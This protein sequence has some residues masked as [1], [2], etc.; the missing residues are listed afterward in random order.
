MEI[1][2][3]TINYVKSLKITNS[4]KKILLGFL[5]Q[6]V[7]HDNWLLR[8]FHHRAESGVNVSE[9]KSW[10]LITASYFII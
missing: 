5:L 4:R 7:G 10:E 2:P 8:S 1:N 6:D 9:K 3:T